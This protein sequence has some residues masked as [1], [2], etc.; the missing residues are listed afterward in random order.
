MRRILTYNHSEYDKCRK[1]G[2]IRKA[3]AGMLV[4]VL[5]VAM[6]QGIRVR[7]AGLPCDAK[8]CQSAPD[9]WESQKEEIRKALDELRDLGF[10]PMDI[11]QNL[12]GKGEET[13]E[14]ADEQNSFLPSAAENAAQELGENLSEKVQEATDTLMEEASQ[15]GSQILNE[16]QDSARKE[17]R[18]VLERFW[19]EIKEKISVEKD[20]DQIKKWHK[21]AAKVDSI[22]EFAEK[23]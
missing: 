4:A 2:Q 23:M 18:N 11:L 22:Q 14:P 19:D 15:T 8:A 3:A 17:A 16:V 12:T 21:L 6:L 7:A 20:V 13:G 9:G 5:A 1:N 10:S